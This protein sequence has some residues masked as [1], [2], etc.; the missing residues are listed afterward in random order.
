M[1]SASTDIN[2]AVTGLPALI[3]DVQSGINQAGAQL[4][5]GNV[6]VATELS[7]A[8]D[9]AV[10][11]V[12]HAQSDGSADPLGAFTRLTQA[13]AELDR[14]LEEV[15]EQRETTERLSRTFDQALF[16][17]QSR[18]RGVSD[19]IDTRRGAI[20]PEARTR[21]AEAVRLLA[22]RRIGGVVI[23]ED[24]Q[25]P[26]GILSE[27]DVVLYPTAAGGSFDARLDNAHP[28]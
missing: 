19:Y 16:N 28:S 1:D 13:D 3:A 18:V 24:G 22:E 15:A 11:A 8:R 5:Q 17:A 10:Q 23:S 27:R 26:L 25:T 21:L 7:D 6:A 2:R 14:L 20:G 4:A 12:S 9:A